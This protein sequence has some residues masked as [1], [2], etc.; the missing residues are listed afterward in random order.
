VIE[1]VPFPMRSFEA[2]AYAEP[3]KDYLDFFSTQ[4]DAVILN[5]PSG[6]GYGLAYV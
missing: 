1:N 2:A 3:P 6:I 4:R 5:L